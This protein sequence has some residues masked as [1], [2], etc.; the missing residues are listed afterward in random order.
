VRV[1]GRDWAA[2]SGAAVFLLCF[3]DASLA[4]QCGRAAWIA[5]GGRTASGERNDGAELTAAH[6]SLP[7]GTKVKVVNVRNGRSVVVRVNDRGASG[8]VIDVS[9]AAAEELGFIRAG[10]ANVRIS[11]PGGGD[12]PA[13]GKCKGDTAGP[14]VMDVALPKGEPSA[15][16]VVLPQAAMP[17]GVPDPLPP[18]AALWDIGFAERFFL[19]FRQETWREEEMRKAIEATLPMGSSQP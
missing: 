18:L 16:E 13:K 2:L 9:R 3:A 4:D 5:P 17:A 10:H 12:L 11:L 19:A 6:A 1:R 7:F 15:T 14:A 8:R